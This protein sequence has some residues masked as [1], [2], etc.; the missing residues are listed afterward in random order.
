MKRGYYGQIDFTTLTKSAKKQIQNLVYGAANAAKV[1]E[2]GSWDF[3]CE[4]DSKSRG[5]A[6]NWDVYAFGKD[7]FS[8]KSLCVI[9]VRQYLKRR[10]NYYPEIKKSYFL[11][12]RNEDK[13]IFAHSVESRVIHSAIKKNV[14]VIKAVQKWIFGCDYKKIIRHGDLALI[15]VKKVSGEILQKQTILIEQSH[16]LNADVL[17]VNGSLYAKNP[18]LEHLQKVHPAIEGKGWY[19]VAVAKRS[20]FWDFAAPTLD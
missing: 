18:K 13:S 11:L 16:M 19:K 4:F 15:P 7:F 9:Q 1:D 14:D 20:K 3:G 12:G 5:S 8:K 2:H 17:K 6:L 10:T